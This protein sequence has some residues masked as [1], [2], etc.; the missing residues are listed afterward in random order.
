MVVYLRIMGPEAEAGPDLWWDHK[1]HPG[2]V[3]DTPLDDI[4]LRSR[5]CCCTEE[6]KC[7]PSTEY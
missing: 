6:L 4:R 1:R 2:T 5:D 3:H 7:L